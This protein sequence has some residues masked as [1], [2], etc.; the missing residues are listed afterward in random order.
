MSHEQGTVNR[1]KAASKAFLAERAAFAWSPLQLGRI[2]VE[3]RFQLFDVLFQ[4]LY[5]FFDQFFQMLFFTQ[6]LP[7]LLQALVHVEH[8]DG[9]TLSLPM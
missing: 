5:I 8:S 3:Y 7:R 1:E 2:V 4:L 9:H 6:N